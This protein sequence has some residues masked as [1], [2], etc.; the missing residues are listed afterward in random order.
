VEACVAELSRKS[1]HVITEYVDLIRR[2]SKNDQNLSPASLAAQLARD[3]IVTGFAPISV[4]S[5]GGWW[6]VSSAKD[7]LIDS[8]GSVTMWNF[9]HI[10][11]LPEAG[12]EA[13]RS[14][15]FLTAF[16]DAVVT[17]GGTEDIIW[18]VGDPDRWPLPEEFAEHFSR[19]V[20][21]RSIAFRW[22]PPS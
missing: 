20:P 8:T 4:D 13:C 14:E 12:R 7:W 5:S 6:F 22:A 21:G 9:S 1:L 17:R 18:I 11:H 2:L 10:V 16:A 3:L 15:I 19:P